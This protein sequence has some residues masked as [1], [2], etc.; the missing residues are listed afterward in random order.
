MKHLRTL[1]MA[2]LLV[3]VLSACVASAGGG[4]PDAGGTPDRKSVV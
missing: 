4:A 1:V 2:L 3:L